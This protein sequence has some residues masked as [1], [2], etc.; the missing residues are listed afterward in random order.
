MSACGKLR[1][2]HE[3]VT[4][5]LSMTTAR[6][7]V[8]SVIGG[9]IPAGSIERDF[10][11]GSDCREVCSPGCTSM[12]LCFKCDEPSRIAGRTVYQKVWFREATYFLRAAQAATQK[13]V[14]Q[15]QRRSPKHFMSWARP[16]GC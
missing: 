5:A 3:C 13:A 14:D 10:S 1:R 7:D 4:L 9:D 8:Q 12:R 2:Y 15:A 11:V 6:I 16:K